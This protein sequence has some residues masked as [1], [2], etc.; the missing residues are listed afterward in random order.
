MKTLT[1]KQAAFRD[2]ILGG[3]KPSEAYRKAFEPKSMSKKAIA[4]EAQKLLRHPKITLAITLATRSGKQ[5]TVLPVLPVT[6]RMSMEERLEELRCA[7]RLDPADIFDDLNHVRSIRE[8]PEH[9]RRAIAGFEVDPVSFVIKIKFVDKRGAI[10]DYSKLMGD[11]PIAALKA[12]EQPGSR[13]P[14]QSLSLEERIK[15]RD[16]IASFLEQRATTT[17]IDTPKNVNGGNGAMVAP[18]SSSFR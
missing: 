4:N 14:W 8:M 2:A 1:T 12:P 10:M 16:M 9:V 3:F 11:I 5:S 18:E 17:S 15:L 7:A 6:V 13:L